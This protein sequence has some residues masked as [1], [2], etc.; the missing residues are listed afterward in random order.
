MGQVDEIFNNLKRSKERLLQQMQDA[1]SKARMAEH[2][3]EL[4]RYYE[5]G[6]QYFSSHDYMKA[7]NEFL[8][9]QSIAPDYK[10]TR[11][12]LKRID[13]YLNQPIAIAAANVQNEKEQTKNS[14]NNEALTLA[15]KQMASLQTLAQK[16]SDIND[17]IIVLSRQ[18]DYEAMRAKF[19]ELENTISALTTIKNDMSSQKDRLKREKQIDQETNRQR[20]AHL[21]LSVSPDAEKYKRREL[22][23]EKNMIFGEAVELY[24]EGKYTQAK[25]LFAELADQH[26]RRGEAW[27]KKSDRAINQDVLRRQVS[28]E[29]ER[30]A[31]IA[32]QLKAQRELIKMQ[33]RERQH[34]KQLTEELER[35]KRLLE[36]Q[37][38][39]QIRKEETLKAQ[40]RERELQE[41]KRLQ[42][43]KETDKEQE[44]LRFRKIDT[45]NNTQPEAVSKPAA[46]NPP[47]PAAAAAAP[48]EGVETQAQLESRRAIVRK[49]LEDGVEAMYQEALSLYKQGDYTDAANRFK[50]V[51]DIIPG[52]KSSGQ[53]MDDARSKSIAEV[54][55]SP[56]VSHQD[57]VSKTLDLFDPN[58]K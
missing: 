16:A 58:T 38:Q 5:L 28:Q 15:Q 44:L 3:E 17:D 57:V 8:A 6:R 31:F 35:Q 13:D 23:Q 54:P 18:Q 47:Q 9:V 33:E 55:A 40:E 49:Q 11:R 34:Q 53:Y 21:S 26:D 24:K 30:T 39:M 12:Y 43:Q 48:V 19:T 14:G 42:M 52:Y 56:S 46:V 4:E 50:D 45:G 41:E 51:Q 37:R 2:K 10:S 1:V 7:Q 25:Y 20:E 29:R 36:E 22:A 32:D 27:L